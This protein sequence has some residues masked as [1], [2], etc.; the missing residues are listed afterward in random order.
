MNMKARHRC[1]SVVGL[2]LFILLLS[3]WNSGYS[4]A[5]D[6]AEERTEGKKG[7]GLSFLPFALYTPETRIAGGV[8][9]I[10]TF[11]SGK[12]DRQNRPNSVSLSVK[13]TQNKQYVVDLTPDLYL[14]GEKYHLKTN[15]VYQ[16]FPLKFYGIGGDTSDDMEESYTPKEIKFKASFQ[17]KVFAGT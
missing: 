11:R 13:Y 17:K 8:G 3:L 5:A 10:Y 16:K 15:I 14:K 12:Y 7:I 2:G 4:F 9:G 1:G 6:S